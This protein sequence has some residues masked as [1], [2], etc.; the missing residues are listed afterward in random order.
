MSAKKRKKK[1]RVK[2]DKHTQFVKRKRQKQKQNNKKSA[3]RKR[4]KEKKNAH[5][6][7]L[8]EKNIHSMLY[9]IYCTGS[10]REKEI[11]KGE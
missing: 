9:C 11:R 4:K 8:Y 6:F 10:A 5:T 2:G 3:E 7:L 1:K